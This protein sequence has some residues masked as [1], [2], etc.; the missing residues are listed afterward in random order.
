MG[1]QYPPAPG[2][3]SGPNTKNPPHGGY[4]ALGEKPIDILLPVDSKMAG[5]TIKVD[6]GNI[7]FISDGVFTSVHINGKSSR[8]VLGCDIKE[9]RLVANSTEKPFVEMKVIPV[10]TTET[11]FRQ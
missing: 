6:V 4:G 1:E 2:G 11:G 7:S 9:F 3:C 10:D 8:D 5:N